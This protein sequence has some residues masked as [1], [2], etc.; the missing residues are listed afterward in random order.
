MI[1]RVLDVD[2]DLRAPA[3]KDLAHGA[4]F[5][6]PTVRED[7]VAD[8]DQGKLVVHRLK[9]STVVAGGKARPWN[10]R[11]SVAPAALDA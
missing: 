1:A 8:L 4:E 11:P 5:L 9:L 3:R 6:G 10:G 2:D 7:L